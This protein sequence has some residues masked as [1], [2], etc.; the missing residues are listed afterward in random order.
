LQLLQKRLALRLMPYRGGILR[1]GEKGLL[2]IRLMGDL[3]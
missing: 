3:G 2:A 1:F